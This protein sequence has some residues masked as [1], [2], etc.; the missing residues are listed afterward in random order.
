MAAPATV[1]RG[2]AAVEGTVGAAAAVILYAIFQSFDATQEFDKEEIKDVHGYDVGWLARNEN[3]KF[4][5]KMKVVGDTAAHAATLFTAVTG[6]TISD[7]G[8]GFIAPLSTLTLS[9]F[10]MAALNGVFQLQ[11]GSKLNQVNDKVAE[12]DLVL[13]KYANADQETAIAVIPT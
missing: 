4:N 3:I 8:Q 13:M 12:Y 10:T 7:A 1:F 11:P 2:K 6:T 5:C 9:G